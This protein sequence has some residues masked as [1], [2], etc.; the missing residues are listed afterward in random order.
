[1]NVE[2][3]ALTQSEHHV[4]CFSEHFSVLSGYFVAARTSPLELIFCLSLFCVALTEKS[5]LGHL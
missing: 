3:R 2:S 4:M 1:M 5:R